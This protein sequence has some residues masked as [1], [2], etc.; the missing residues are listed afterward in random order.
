MDSWWA[1][2][3]AFIGLEALAGN[4]DEIGAR[5]LVSYVFEEEILDLLVTRNGTYSSTQR[6]TLSTTGISG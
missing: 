4:P 2:G 1:F 6:Y 5:F 3:F